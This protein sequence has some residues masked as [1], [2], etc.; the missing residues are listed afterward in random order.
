MTFI[1]H[2]YEPLSDWLDRQA[3]ELFQT[4][5]P[6]A[7]TDQ[8]ISDFVEKRSTVA[9]GPMVSGNECAVLAPLHENA[10]AATIDPAFSSPLLLEGFSAGQAAT[11]AA[12][13]AARLALADHRQIVRSTLDG[14]RAKK[15]TELKERTFQR[16]HD[17]FYRGDFETVVVIADGSMQPIA[18]HIW[19]S[20]DAAQMVATCSFAGRP[21]LIKNMHKAKAG[22]RECRDWLIELMRSSRSRKTHSKEEL[23][24]EAKSKFDIGPR[25]FKEQWIKALDTVG[26]DTA[27]IWGKRGSLIGKKKSR[28]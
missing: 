3:Q 5:Y 9:P 7:I 24:A 26:Q 16:H 4:E 27:E 8:D 6:S 18:A 13:I 10:V 17:R 1:P 25:A 22:Q 2:G 11:D 23:T 20:D 12:L 14:E 19:G 15:I 21:I 28:R